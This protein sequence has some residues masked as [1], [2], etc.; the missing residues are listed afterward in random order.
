MGA[1]MPDHSSARGETLTFDLDEAQVLLADNVRRLVRH[2]YSFEQRK[3]HV[4][5]RQRGPSLFWKE[6]AKLGLLGVEIEERYGGSGGSFYDLAIVLEEFGR[7]L[8]IE[9]FVSTVVIGA[10]LLARAGNED[11]KGRLLPGIL[12]GDI[13]L[14]LAYAEANSR[15]DLHS[16]ATT[17]TRRGDGFVIAGSKAVVL[18]ADDADVLI[19][20]AR[21]DEGVS[22]FLVAREALGL[23]M[24]IYDGI[25]DRRGAEVLLEAVRVNEDAV[26]G[27]LGDGLRQLEA[28]VDRGAAAM[29]CEA[30]G[31]IAV[32]NDL[33]LEYLKTRQQF[34]RP[35]GKF[36][37]LAHRMA[38]MKIAEQLARSV[39]ALATA[40]ANSPDAAQRA[41][42]IS[43]AKAQVGAAAQTVG[44]G[45]IQLHG[46][47]GLT[48]EYV[49]GHYFRRLAAIEMMFGDQAYHLNRYA[50]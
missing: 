39:L 34:G 13:R 3:A 33:T 31:A 43:A 8:V 26:L 38:D 22:L 29:C 18:G 20:S 40:Y 47:I 24:R 4:R 27:G 41:K 19:V 45:A 15:Y 49:A 28:A 12:A 11:Q 21:S 46:G 25:D 48:I 16:V 7:G 42:A 30:V 14:A 17:A 37:V 10:G 44:R 9:P 23:E 32:L 5:D 50:A 35:L 2:R 6:C 36:Q 1:F